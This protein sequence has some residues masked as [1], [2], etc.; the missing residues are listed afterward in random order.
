MFC[1]SVSSDFIMM[2]PL[3]W[4]Q[5]ILPSQHWFRYRHGAFR[6]QAITWAKVDPV[7]CNHMVSLGPFELNSLVH[8]VVLTHWCK[9]M[10][11]LERRFYY[12]DAN[13]AEGPY[14]IVMQRQVT[15]AMP[16]AVYKINFKMLSEIILIFFAWNAGC[17]PN[18]GKF[19]FK[20]K[21]R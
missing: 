11:F 20:P 19:Y 21:L 3:V 18:L 15:I 14:G 5:R 6:L 12:S 8:V 7:L 1:W 4:P 17:S 9:S 10:P 16:I 13:L 2:I